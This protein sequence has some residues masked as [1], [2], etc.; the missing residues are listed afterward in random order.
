MRM[1]IKRCFRQHSKT[2]VHVFHCTE[3]LCTIRPSSWG[4]TQ[5]M[6][7]S[8]LIVYPCI[9]LYFGSCWGSFNH[10]LKPSVSLFL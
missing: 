7:C 9:W 6:R 5:N 2:E 3:R 10:Y 4:L 1:N 8:R